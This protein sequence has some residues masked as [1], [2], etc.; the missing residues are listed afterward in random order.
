MAMYHSS[1]I[2]KPDVA[3]RIRHYLDEEPKNESEALIDDVII[4]STA[5]PNGY[6]IEVQCCGV[7]YFDEEPATNTAWGQ[8]VLF[9]EHGYEVASEMAELADEFFDDW[10]LEGPDGN[11]YVAHILVNKE[12][13]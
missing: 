7:S 5:Y 4:H 1:I 9:N 12:D 6:E 3:E 13:Q 11:I 2:I 8:A 10:T